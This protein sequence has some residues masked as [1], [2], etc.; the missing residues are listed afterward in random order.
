VRRQQHYKA[1]RPRPFPREDRDRVTILIGGLTWKHERLAAAAMRSL[2]YR[3]EILPNPTKE[4][5]ETGKEL[6]DTGACCPTYFT[7]GCLVNTLRKKLAIEG[8]D[9]VADGYVFLTAGSCGAC[10]FGQ[11]HVSYALALENIGLADLRMFRFDQGKVST[12]SNGGQGLDIDVEFT[13]S[14][15]WAFLCADLLGDL[16]YMARPY[17]VREGE[18]ERVLAESLAILEKAFLERPRHPSRMGAILWFL[19]TGYFTR[20]LRRVAA[21]WAEIPVDRLRVKPKVKITGEIW[22]QTHE[23]EG[24]YGIKRWLEREGAEVV[25]PPLAVWVDYMLYERQFDLKR[26]RKPSALLPLKAAA[27]RLMRSLY[28][29]AYERLRHALGDLPDSLPEQEELVRLAAPF[30]DFRLNGG[31]GYM[32]IGK[33]LLA[34]RD[35]LAH[36]VCEVAPFGCMPSTMSVGAMANVLGRYPDL[37]HAPIEV[38]GDAEIHALSRCQMVLTEARRHAEQEFEQV[39]IETGLPVERIRA[40]EAGHPEALRLGTRI[41]HAGAAGTAA[42]YVRYVATAMRSE[43]APTG[44]PLPPTLATDGGAS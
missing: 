5:F 15:L 12:E 13:L 42:N 18:T 43:A 14:V 10:R 37:L 20:A 27:F 29:R 11:Y 38:K 30:Y 26:Q 6:V 9:A 36:M 32:L 34:Y 44:E 22:L 24:N 21:R 2:G 16:E 41:P 4:D 31:E 33:A 39:L 19:T 7:A 40:W 17:E 35:H 1:Y 8:R 28:E 25:P 23:G 3:V